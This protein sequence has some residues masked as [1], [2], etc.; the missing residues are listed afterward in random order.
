MNLFCIDTQTTLYQQCQHLDGWIEDF[1]LKP[2]C[3][4]SVDKH[5]IQCIVCFDLCIDS[6]DKHSIQCIT[7]FDL[8]IDSVDKEDTIHNTQ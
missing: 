5:N 3:I 7:C 4:N 1:L 6:V 8:C 2:P